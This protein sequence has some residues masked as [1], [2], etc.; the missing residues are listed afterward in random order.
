MKKFSKPCHEVVYFNS[1]V[2]AT[3]TCGC[4]DGEDDWGPGGN[5]TGDVAYCEC[6]ENHIA[7]TANCTPCS[8]F[9]G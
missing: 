1:S 5:C 3:S 4:W 2:I 6:Q 9:N 7:G 8:E